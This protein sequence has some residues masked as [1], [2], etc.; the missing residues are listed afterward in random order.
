[1]R[2]QE[3]TEEREQLNEW[4]PLAVW[5]G[6]ILGTALSRLGAKQFIKK[7]GKKAFDWV[8]QQTK[9]PDPVLKDKPDIKSVAKNLPKNI[10]KVA[11]QAAN[12]IGQ[13]VEV[14]GN[15]V[16]VLPKQQPKTQPQPKP[17]PK[18]EPKPQ[19]KPEPKPVVPKPVPKPQPKPE[20]KPAPKPEP[21]PQ[22]KPEPKP[23]P[24]PEPK[25]QPK[26]E[27]K[28]EP[29]PTPQVKVDPA[30]PIAVPS[31]RGMKLQPKPEP[32]PKVQP[33]P[34][35]RAKREPAPTPKSQTRVRRQTRIKP[36]VPPA[37]PGQNDGSSWQPLHQKILQMKGGPSGQ[38]ILQYGV[39]GI[40]RGAELKEA[41]LTEAVYTKQ[42][43]ADLALKYAKMYDVPPALALHVL[44]RES[45]IWDAKKASS[46][47]SPKGAV[48]VMQILPD[49]GKELGLSPKDLQNPRKNIEAGVRYLAQQYNKYQN[50]VHALAAYNWGPGNTNKWLARGGKGKLP[51]ETRDYIYGS[52]QK[53]WAP[54]KGNIQTQIQS[55][56]GPDAENYLA[57]INNPPALK[58]LPTAPK[59]DPRK[60]NPD[61]MA[62]GVKQ[63]FDNIAQTAQNVAKAGYGTAKEFYK[64]APEKTP[65]GLIKHAGSSV[66]DTLGQKWQNFKTNASDFVSQDAAKKRIQ[67]ATN[68]GTPQ[69]HPASSKRLWQPEKVL[70]S[71][72]QAATDFYNSPNV[73][74]IRQQSA[75]RLDYIK[76]NWKDFKTW[77]GTGRN[78][79]DEWNPLSIG[80]TDP[81][82]DAQAYTWPDNVKKYGKV[83]EK[84][85]PG[86]KYERMVKHV[87]KG[88]AKDGKLTKREKGIAYATAWK[89]YNKDKS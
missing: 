17:Q 35:P 68:E 18:P 67:Q 19:P 58:Q 74:D 32:G 7:Y 5:G 30:E 45:G 75:D 14:V 20:P 42:Q 53:G 2:V 65:V 56:L 1:M 69:G 25:S 41:E 64:T 13:T 28:L 60:L 47:V 27:P 24:K 38:T 23:Q 52:K 36:F 29:A 72:A 73:K 33:K 79:N 6:R 39:P 80:P 81:D 40:E 34:Y 54:Y 59:A 86:D 85:P 21:K 71:V 44:N 15:V 8:K 49:T 10:E 61:Q 3:L 26:P 51:A 83:Q 46:V 12:D 88:Y 84:A 70:P 4:V 62:L 89:H 78:Y 57:K 16:R 77:D 11:K 9:N 66:A 22:P 31:P 87:K 76:R 82:S 63:G 43:Y 48:G 55:Y 37:L 50:P